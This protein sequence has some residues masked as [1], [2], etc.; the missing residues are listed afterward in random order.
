[1]KSV[2]ETTR[3]L[4]EYCHG[5][6]VWA[7]PNAQVNVIPPPTIPSI[8]AAMVSAIYNPNIVWDEY[9]ARFAGRFSR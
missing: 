7:H 3:L 4:A 2:A 1:M 8:L 6:T 5:M 9:A